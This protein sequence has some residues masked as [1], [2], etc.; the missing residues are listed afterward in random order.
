MLIKETHGRTLLKTIVYRV[1]CT[2]AVFLI[3][4]SLGADSAASG[5]LALIVVVFG[6]IVYYVHDRVWN[7]FA[8][9]RDETG[10]E[11]TRRSLVKTIVYRLITVI[12]GVTL[13]RMIITDSTQTALVFGVAQFV[14][15]MI[16]YYLVE[17][18]FN[19]LS[20]GRVSVNGV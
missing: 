1:L 19:K 17:R 14:V 18:V 16:L 13:A 6:T 11:S 12:I 5:T 15:N 7:R 3:A 4:T 10:A 8:W 2:I 9:N 20:V